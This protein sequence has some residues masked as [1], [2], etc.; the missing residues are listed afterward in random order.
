[1]RQKERATII[2]GKDGKQS[3]IDYYGKRPAKFVKE[4]RHALEDLGIETTEE[5]LSKAR[6]SKLKKRFREIDRNK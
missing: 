2:I 5:H 6:R 4:L 1:M 3:T